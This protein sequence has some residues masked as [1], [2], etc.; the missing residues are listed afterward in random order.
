MSNTINPQKAYTPVPNDIEA[1]FLAK[2]APMVRKA[3]PM[4]TRQYKE[5][6]EATRNY[7]R[8]L[9]SNCYLP[10]DPVQDMLKIMANAHNKGSM[11]PWNALRPL[12]RSDRVQE[13]LSSIPANET[14]RRPTDDDE[15]DEE[16]E[17]EEGED[18]EKSTETSEEEDSSSE[19]DSDGPQQEQLPRVLFPKPRKPAS[20]GRSH[21]ENKGKAPVKNTTATLPAPRTTPPWVHSPSKLPEEPPKGQSPLT[22]PTALPPLVVT[23]THPPGPS[24]APPPTQIPAPP[25]PA[26]PSSIAADHSKLAPSAPKSAQEAPATTPA[27]PSNVESDSKAPLPE[28]ALTTTPAPSSHVA[29]ASEV[30]LLLAGPVAMLTSVSSATPANHSKPDTFPPMSAEAA[31]ASPTTTPAPSNVA[32]ASKASHPPAGPVAMPIGVPSAAAADRSKVASPVPRSAE[33]GSAAPTATL[34][35]DNNE[36][37]GE[38]DD[39]TDPCDYCAKRETPCITIGKKLACEPCS[40]LKQK[41]SLA[42]IRKEQLLSLQSDSVKPS[43]TTRSASKAVEEQPGVIRKRAASRPAEEPKAKR[44]KTPVPTHSLRSTRAKLTPPISPTSPGRT[45]VQSMPSI[46]S[47][48]K[49][50]SRGTPSLQ[51]AISHA[52]SLLQQRVDEQGCELETLNGKVQVLQEAHLQLQEDHRRLQ[53][54]HL[55]LLRHMG[56]GDMAGQIANNS[57]F[58]GSPEQVMSGPSFLALDSHD[59]SLPPLNASLGTSLLLFDPTTAQRVGRVKVREPV[60]DPPPKSTL[61]RPRKNLSTSTRK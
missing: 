34:V 27:P 1:T 11:I 25:P 56:L 36:L 52:D 43:R 8:L 40:R 29:T 15:E 7:L 12:V 55:A 18:D 26:V 35:Q 49:N 13:L 60:M 54:A 4:Q 17:D 19:D 44:Q 20:P 24:E 14:H 53:A 45:L 46:A 23:S 31:P 41:C 58:E 21:P 30:P 39:G 9:H 3:P 61:K 22:H 38:P 10:S 57:T 37:L 16:G 5:I 51:L 48:S 32:S 59:T 2:L 50:P 28:M 6:E 47:S 33:A 42:D